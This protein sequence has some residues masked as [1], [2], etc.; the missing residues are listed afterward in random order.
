LLSTVNGISLVACSE[1]QNNIRNPPLTRLERILDGLG[2]GSLTV[3]EAAHE[4]R[5]FRGSSPLPDSDVAD[6]LGI[7]VSDGSLDQDVADALQRALATPA[8]AP[9]ATMLRPATDVP[10]QVRDS[11]PTPDAAPAPTEASGAGRSGSWRRWAESEST[12]TRIGV[13]YVIRDRFVIEE[14][15]GEGGMGVVFRAR[16]HRREEAR[17]RNPFVAIKVLTE[18]FKQHPD[19]LVALQR[20]ARRMQQL[21]HPN[22]A[23]VYDFDRDGSHVY[24]VMELLEG[25]SLD[26]MLARQPGTGLPPE[27]ARAVI[28]GAGSALRHAHSRGV[29][30]SDFKPANVFVMR[31]GEVKVIDFGIARIAKDATPGNDAAL[32]VFD[33]G[34]LGAWTNAYA[35]PEQMLAAAPPDPRDDVYAFGLVAYEALTGRHPFGR[36]SAVDARFREMK[37][38]PVVGITQA[39][40]AALARA[41]DFDRERRLA[42]VMELV[43]AFAPVERPI[44]ATRE[45][46]PAAARPA[47]ADAAPRKRVGR[48]VALTIAGIAWL[49]FF[50]A[51]WNA[52][53]DESA[54]PESPPEI[55]TV[56]S[57][58]VSAEGIAEATPSVAET[59]PPASTQA[60]Q[61]PPA[62]AS[63]PGS[64]PATVVPRA[65]SQGPGIEAAATASETAPATAPAPA[66]AA[67]KPATSD[68]GAGATAGAGEPAEPEAAAQL[69]QWIDKDGK[70]Q[71]G[72]N[73]P[74]EYADTA[75][76]VMDL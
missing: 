56:E 32:T 58:A 23:A 39:Q 8:A 28:E 34:G 64:P 55:P 15:V 66:T 11:P 45:D 38:E 42:D 12:D 10:A 16:D 9:E 25:D 1:F 48:T 53:K 26:R 22:I 7:R 51:Y 67:A 19:A 68:A 27:Q 44:T 74:P 70:V 36:K 35:S 6:A 65:T 33:A 71:F 29:V 37:F 59:S 60:R 76:K 17:D 5:A 30:H 14:L 13:G 61:A 3:P 21:S 41:L 40:N 73:P 75:V 62:K 63:P 2:D 24:L 49:G 72:E 47:I 4:I 46:A 31:S 18:D 20:E 52:K 50:A 54:R 43:H 57:P 69:Y